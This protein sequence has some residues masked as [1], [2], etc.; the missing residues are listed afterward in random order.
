MAI[1]LISLHACN[2]Q[3]SPVQLLLTCPQP[4]RGLLLS[5]DAFAC[6]PL[7]GHF[8]KALPTET[9]DRLCWNLLAHKRGPLNPK[10]LRIMTDLFSLRTGY[11]VYCICI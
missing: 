3:F 2:R 7:I 11:S 5:S 9:N 8:P 10:M 4:S 1:T 6:I